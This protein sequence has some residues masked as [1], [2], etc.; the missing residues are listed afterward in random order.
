MLQLWW[1]IFRVARPIHHAKC[2]RSFSTLINEFFLLV[3]GRS[4]V[5][6]LSLFILTGKQNVW[7]MKSS[8]VELIHFH[9]KNLEKY[10]VICEW[11][12]FLIFYWENDLNS[13]NIFD[14]S[15]QVFSFKICCVVFSLNWYPFKLFIKNNGSRSSPT[16][17]SSAHSLEIL[18]SENFESSFLKKKK[19][20]HPQSL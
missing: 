1:S 15:I 10:Y 8:E 7:Q 4:V 9:F 2:E 6:L 13:L 11:Q 18:Y 3:V 16:S 19:L 20:L 12:E 14:C 17:T 5:S